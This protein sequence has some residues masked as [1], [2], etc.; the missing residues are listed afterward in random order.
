MDAQNALSVA[1]L[2]ESGTINSKEPTSVV[3]RPQ[4]MTAAWAR[5]GV[6]TPAMGPP[7]RLREPQER[8]NAMY[9]L[10]FALLPSRSL[11]AEDRVTIAAAAPT[12]SCVLVTTPPP[13]KSRQQLRLDLL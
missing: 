4:A 11:R 12:C 8:Y 5:R 9:R 1:A 7:V 2:T 10:H 3:D 6:R 13:T